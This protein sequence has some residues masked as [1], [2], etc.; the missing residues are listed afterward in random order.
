[1]LHPAQGT[2]L[3][4]VSVVPLTKRGSESDEL[5]S[6][7][8]GELEIDTLSPARKTSRCGP[9]APTPAADTRAMPAV[10]MA[11][12]AA[13]RDRRHGRRFEST[14]RIRR[15]V[16]RWLARLILATLPWLWPGPAVAQD[17][18]GVLSGSLGSTYFYRAWTTQGGLPQE[19]VP[20]IAQTSDGYL[21]LGTFGG[22]VR[23]N[24]TELRVFDLARHPELAN[25]RVHALFTDRRGALWIGHPYGLVSRFAGRRFTAY[26]QR[27]GVPQGIVYAI[28]EDLE[29]HLWLGAS[30]GLAR[31]R[32]DAFETFTE[33][34]GLPEG[35][36]LSLAVDRHG[37]LW[38]GT[39]AGLV[40]HAGNKASGRPVFVGVD[41]LSGV[42]IF[43]LLEDPDGMLWLDSDQ[44]LM[45]RH[46][47]RWQTVLA[48]ERSYPGTRLA[49]DRRGQ[50]WYAAYESS[51]LYRFSG[52]DRR[53]SLP[54]AA[55]FV[56]L[57]RPAFAL[58]VDREDNLWLGTQSRGLWRL[59][60]Q[61]VTRWTTEHGL[62]HPEIRTVTADGEG[63]LWL[64]SGCEM[65]LT[66][67]RAGV[68][69]P[70]PAAAEGHDLGCASSFLR[71]RQGDFWLG[72]GGH[73]VRFRNDAV[74][75]RHVLVDTRDHAINAIFEDA[76]GRLWIG[77]GAL[78]LARFDGGDV[79]F[80]TCRDGLAGNYVQ[81]IAEDRQGALWIGTG[82]GLSR[83]AEG[84]FTSYTRDDGLPAGAVRAIHPD[85]DGT[86][87]IGTYGG[88]L[89]RL[90]HGARQG[91]QIVRITM[92]DGLFDNVVTRILEDER[93]NFWMLGNR[94]LFFVHRD[95][96]N[97]FAD[98][99]RDSVDSV[100]FGPA[101]GM[102]E[103][104]GGR[105][106][107]GWRT[108]DGKMWFP[109]VDGLAMIDAR[110]FRINEVAPLVVIERAEAGGRELA[111]A[112]E[113]VLETGERDLEIHYAASSYA[114]PERVRF[115]Y[116]M[117]G[118]DERWLDAGNRRLAF[119]T[120]LSPGAYTFRVTAANHHGVW[121]AVGASIR[122]RV[123]P[124]LW[125]TWWAYGLYALALSG[126]V[127]G[128]LRWQQ[129]R[130]ERQQAI[131]ERERAAGDRLREANRLK[132]QLLAERARLIADLEAKNSELARINYTVSHDL[133]N[134]LVTILNYLGLARRDV[135]AGR[136]ERLARDLDRLESAAGKL[137]QQL[138]ELF[139]LSRIGLQ[140]NPPE[141]VAFG[142]LVEAALEDLAGA[143]AEAGMEV[144]LAADLPAV[145]GDRLRLEE[146]VRHLLDN[147]V[148]YRGDQ[149]APRVEVGLRAEAAERVFFFRDNGRGIEPRY[150]ERVF[151]LF[152]RL[153]PGT[154][155]GTGI[156]LTL[157]KRIVEVHGGRVWVESAG[158]GE[159][160]TFCFTLPASPTE[161][162]V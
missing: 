46:R 130:L 31:L 5:V 146:A 15:Q 112:P 67:W 58:H 121:N 133:K 57:E 149:P 44:G 20:A 17:S 152:E 117:E 131:A 134:P 49:L 47:G 84:T 42:P 34:D 155:K 120:N 83:L 81:F 70:H 98:G 78:G 111:P 80:Y 110:N 29:G 72:T 4:R 86:L 144:E 21:W 51:R 2:E 53:A 142:E 65:P 3:I 161:G 23:F 40:R 56:E 154:S 41:G 7:S 14:P 32:D 62:P 122:F 153:D 145:R 18:T 115:R 143:I 54:L 59:E 74:I 33:D 39:S 97:A 50:L 107:A 87:W 71:D 95:Q 63:G 28:V 55:E 106:P 126:L 150:H 140:A 157:V 16:P 116:R 99:E 8:P 69:S 159:G 151:G 162:A 103:G 137:H 160:A 22:L 61:P 9:W 105:Q 45:R 129:A 1:M 94:G 124:P 132:D 82:D 147:A 10:G 11:A 13:L 148:R 35:Q 91:R 141:E 26:G 156:G 139:E 88:G 136:G 24:G 135:A 119:Y 27:D 108:D 38:A 76:V 138:E 19:S 90:R 12:A 113:I 36:V 60:R 48:S 109:T 25:N 79:R 93:G 96:L 6:P 158:G 104:S 52:R 73:L 64:A 128:L 101:E 118:Y 92:D 127:V 43:S 85:D 77:F 30:G 100:S 114:A 68:F 123:P 66:R 75:A 102:T 37:V 125:R 89:G